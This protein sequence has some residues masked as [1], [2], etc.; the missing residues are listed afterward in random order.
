MIDFTFVTYSGMP[1]LDL[2]DRLAVAVLEQ[3]GLH[4][5]AAVWDDEA[6]DWSCAGTVVIRSTWDYNRRRDAFVRWSER[7][8]ELTALWN[9]PALVRWN[10]DKGYM[11]DLQAAGVAVV[12]TH[13]LRR[14]SA[15]DI[16]EV[17][18]AQ[19]WPVAVVKPRVGLS[20]YGVRRI[21]LDADNLAAAQ[22]HV[23]ELLQ[24]QDVMVQPYLSSVET[25]GE[26]ALVFIRGEYSHAARK[27]AFQPLLPTGE[28]GETPATATREEIA[29]AE[30]ALQ[31][32]PT[33]ALYARADI[34]RDDAGDPLIIEFEM[35]EPTLFLSMHP[36]APERF[37]DALVSVRR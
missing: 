4:T 5:Q 18:E 27:T 19:R 15:V 16:R 1:E 12:P 21:N 32:L 28:A 34:V 33:W 30:A 2:D 26:R 29:V 37:A 10:T 20:T 17:M 23:A 31:A 25:Y 11:D 9:P 24:E 13:W 7:V 6:V 36:R 35:V 3:R 22:R 8:G 14:G